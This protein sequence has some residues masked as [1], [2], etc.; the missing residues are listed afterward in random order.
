MQKQPGGTLIGSYAVPLASEQFDSLRNDS[1][2][3]PFIASAMK[4]GED[5]LVLLVPTRP[6]NISRVIFYRRGAPTAFSSAG[7]KN[8]D[9]TKTIDENRVSLPSSASFKAIERYDLEPGELRAD[10]DEPV[11]AFLVVEKHQ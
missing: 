10:N 8:D 11:K 3:G 2:L 6:E 4:N 9:R 1:D 5:G 7:K